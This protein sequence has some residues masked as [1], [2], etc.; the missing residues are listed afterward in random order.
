MVEIIQYSPSEIVTTLE[1]NSPLARLASSGYDLSSYSKS[2]PLEAALA[3]YNHPD[4]EAVIFV[5]KE[6]EEAVGSLVLMLWKDNPQDKRGSKFWPRLRGLDPA[7]AER[8]SQFNH[9]AC[10]VGGVVVLPQKRNQGIGKLL[11]QTGLE[12]INPGIL[13][14]QTRTPQAVMLR[15]KLSGFRSIYGQTEVTTSHPQPQTEEHLFLAEAY[16]L[17]LSAIEV[18]HQPGALVYAFATGIAAPVPD[19]SGY[20]DIIK[21]SFQPVIDFQ[22]KLNAEKNRGHIV[23]S[24]ILSIREQALW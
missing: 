4:D 5:A 24:P 3:E 23:M 1:E 17:A 10:D 12:V 14:G 7:L 8:L 16:L 22:S 9:L 21:Q 20:P 13:V 6:G 2:H 15:S 11:Y 18:N 19:V